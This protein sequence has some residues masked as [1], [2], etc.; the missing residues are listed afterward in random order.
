MFFL[1]KYSDFC[2]YF[3]P[4]P[5]GD[6]NISSRCLTQLSSSGGGG[7]DALSQLR[8]SVRIAVDRLEEYMAVPLP[9]E[10]EEEDVR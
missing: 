5:P 10:G 9:K 2:T 3:F 8:F 1:K 4:S 7:D 6:V